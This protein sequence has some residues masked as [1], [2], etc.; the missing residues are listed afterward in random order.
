MC[1]RE[2]GCPK[3]G[4]LITTERE[5]DNPVDKYAVCVKKSV[6][7]VGHLP[8]GKTGNFS[9]TVFYFLR[10]DEYGSCELVVTGKPFFW[11][12]ILSCNVLVRDTFLNVSQGITRID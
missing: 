11:H 12:T 3:Q 1:I 8:L 10:A 7:I 9:K 5:S 2:V 6:K 4:E